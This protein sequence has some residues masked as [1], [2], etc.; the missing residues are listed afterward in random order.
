MDCARL[1]LKKKADMVEAAEPSERPDASEEYLCPIS[2]DVMEDPVLAADGITYERSAIEKWIRDK[3]DELCTV[4]RD[5]SNCDATARKA[6]QRI[7][8]TAVKSPIKGTPLLSLNLVPNEELALKI[9][10]FRYCRRESGIDRYDSNAA[11]GGSGGAGSGRDGS[12]G[13]GG[14]GGAGCSGG[15]GG[16]ASDNDGGSGCIV[17]SGGGRSRN[18][19]CGTIDVIE[20]QEQDL[21]S[22]LLLNG[23]EDVASMFIDEEFDAGAFSMLKEIDLIDMKAIPA[24]RHG[25]LLQLAAALR[26]AAEKR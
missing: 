13:G 15:G 2:K 9:H 20:T 12:G 3:E 4:R 5:I 26:S 14:S 6:F 7:I 1:Q 22:I 24:S 16:G 21:A 8:D 25:A 10:F 18:D 23:F 19:Q 17:G 11:G